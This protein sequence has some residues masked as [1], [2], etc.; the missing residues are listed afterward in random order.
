MQ[1]LADPAS[2]RQAAAATA[3]SKTRQTSIE[4][5]Q[6]SIE[7]SA[8]PALRIA[9]ALE[10]ALE[11]APVAVGLFERGQDLFEV[12]AH[13]DVPPPRD[14]LLELIAAAAPGEG[15]GPLRIEAIPPL[16]WVRLS[17]GKRGK[18]EAGRFLIHG[19]HDR[20]TV[21]RRRL[22]VE[23]DAGRAFG[24]A[25]HAST[26]GCLLALDHLLK[27]RRP[28]AIVDLGTGSGILA[29]AAA[30]ALG[31]SV[32]ACDSDP[33]AAAAAEGNARKNGVQSLMGVVVA[34]GFAHRRLRHKTADL[35]LANLLERALHGLAPELA[36]RIAPGG[37]A[38][39]SGLADTQAR[40]IEART[41]ALGFALEKRI[42]LDGWTTLVIV[43]RGRRRVHH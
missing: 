38:I 27:R 31:Q 43:R 10:E 33:V 40:G 26:R 30:K 16:D 15:V 11:P 42:I 12:F 18:V 28:R 24:S 25:H 35:V 32:L 41:R 19:S 21:P 4:T 22:A 7:A 6:A 3:A 17:Q 23:I 1:V 13:Y 29:I 14:A 36:R 20:G 9:Q 2:R 5:H 39:L 37:R 8:S 34:Q